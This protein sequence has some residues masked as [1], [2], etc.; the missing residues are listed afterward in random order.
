MPTNVGGY[1]NTA[2]DLVANLVGGIAIGSW[3]LVEL[4]AGSGR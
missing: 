1:D 4:R 2:R 3:T